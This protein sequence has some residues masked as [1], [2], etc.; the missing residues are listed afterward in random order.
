MDLLYMPEMMSF[1]SH[2]TYYTDY[3]NQPWNK[4][5]YN[6]NYGTIVSY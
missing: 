3:S 5:Y 6:N 2:R 1:E 4:N